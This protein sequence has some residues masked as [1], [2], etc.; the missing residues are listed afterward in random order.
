MKEIISYEDEGVDEEEED[1]NRFDLPPIFDDYGDDELLDFKEL[2]ETAG[3]SSFCEEEEQVRKE[4]LHLPLS[5]DFHH[6]D[7]EINFDLPPRFDEHEDDEGLWK[8][9]II[10]G[11]PEK[12]ELKQEEIVQGFEQCS[13]QGGC[14]YTQQELRAILS[15]QG[16]Y[17]AHLVRHHIQR[18]SSNSFGVA[19]F[20]I[21]V[22]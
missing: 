13:T 3:P 22:W 12:F 1:L 5:K 4:E 8:I 6:E 7:N 10:L 15:Q 21:Q 17:D 9:L 14:P 19:S 11:G 16:E 18:C 2:G 20:Q